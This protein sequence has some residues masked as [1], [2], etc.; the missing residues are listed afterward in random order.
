LNSLPTITLQSAAEEGAQP[1]MR[2]HL[3]GLKQNVI[4]PEFTV[5]RTVFAGSPP[6]SPRPAAY[7]RHDHVHEGRVLHAMQIQFVLCHE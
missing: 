5:C 6:T 7:G 1:R 3:P 4:Q 2:Y